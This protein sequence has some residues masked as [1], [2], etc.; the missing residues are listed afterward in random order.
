MGSLLSPVVSNFYM[1]DYEKTALESAPPKNRCWFR[2][3]HDKFVIWPDKLKDYL[4]HL[5]SIHQ[6]TQFTMK[7][8]SES[9][10]PFLDLHTYGRHDGFL[11]HNVYC[12]PNSSHLSFGLPTFLVP[13]FFF[14]V[15][16]FS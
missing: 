9:H 13:P 2:Y 4:H 7:T 10:L 11:G 14:V 3:V 6:S 1:E 16:I 5:N 8:E 12:K 15:L